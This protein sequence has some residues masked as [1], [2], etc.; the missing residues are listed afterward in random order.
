M[1]QFGFVQKR[2][3]Y[4]LADTAGAILKALLW[5]WTFACRVPIHD[6]LTAVR[7][8]E[9]IQPLANL[10]RGEMVHRLEECEQHDQHFDDNVLKLIGQKLSHLSTRSSSS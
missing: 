7:A 10:E 8:A 2:F 6:T 5:K 4:S 1:S 9:E 3:T